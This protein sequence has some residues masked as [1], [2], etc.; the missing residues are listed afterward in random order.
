[1]KAKNGISLIV[2][3]ITIIVIIILA[4]A[5]I[6][7]LSQSNPVDQAKWATFVNQ[8]ADIQDMI[9][10]EIVDQFSKNAQTTSYE[11]KNYTPVAD[12]AVEK[13]ITKFNADYN[14][15]AALVDG[16]VEVT[17]GSTTPKYITDKKSTDGGNIPP[18]WLK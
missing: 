11:L 6:L 14:V 9:N 12:G 8:K 16:Q 17:T 1:M 18:A 13:A 15:T 3:V 7:S 4:G 10:L 5:V 2:L